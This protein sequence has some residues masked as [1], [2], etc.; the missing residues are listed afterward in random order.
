MKFFKLLPIIVILGLSYSQDCPSNQYVN[1]S[2]SAEVEAWKAAWGDCT[3]YTLEGLQITAND[4]SYLENT[5]SGLR[6]I[7]GDLAFIN[8][9]NLA[10]INDFANLTSIG[11]TL[12]SINTDNL[13]SI[14]G[15]GSN[16]LEVGGIYFVNND[17]LSNCATMPLTNCGLTINS[18]ETTWVNNNECSSININGCDGNCGSFS[19]WD[20]GTVLLDDCA[21]TCDGSATFWTSEC[22][23]FPNS[24]EC[25]MS[26]EDCNDGFG[27]CTCDVNDNIDS[28][29]VVGGDG[30]SCCPSNQNQYVSLSSSAEVEAWKA[31]WGNCGNYT[32]ESLQITANDLSYLE[33]TFSGLRSITGDLAFINLDNL[34]YINDFANL[35]S[36]GGTLRSINTDNLTSIMG[37]GSNGLEVGGIY[38]VNN[39]ALSNCA[40]MPLTN[41]GLTINSGETTWVNNNECSS[42]NINGCD[43][44]CGSFSYW[45]SGTVLL[46]DCAGT[47][48]GPATFWTSECDIY[49][50]NSMECTM[51]QED[52]ND[53][54]GNC[55]CLAGPPVDCV[56][57]WSESSACS[58]GD[59]CGTGTTSQTYTVTT[60]AA[61]GGTACEA[62][63]GAVATAACAGTGTLDNCSVC[64][65][66]DS[67]CTGCADTTANNYDE[68]NTI[69][70]NTACV[71]PV[72]CVGTWSAPTACSEGD[73]CGTGTTSQTYTVTTDAANGG[74]ACEAADGAVATAACDGTGSLDSCSVCNGD[75]STCAGCDGIA[76]SGLVFDEC[77][78][79]NGSGATSDQY[80]TGGACIDFTVCASAQYESTPPTATSDRQCADVTTCASA[81][82]ESTPPTAT[83]D[84]QCADV[85]T[86]PA[87]YGVFDSATETSDTVCGPCLDGTYSGG[88]DLSACTATTTCT[89]GNYISTL[90]TTTSDTVCSTCSICDDGYYASYACEPDST[91]DTVC[92]LSPVD[93]VGSWSAPTACSEGDGCGAG[94]TSSTYTV[95]TAAVGSGAACS[96]ADGDVATVA[97]AGT[98]SLDS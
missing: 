36:I 75:N 11:G 65:G 48:D 88:D 54:F 85:T 81:Q 67:T 57:T 7:T 66:D 33:N 87:G 24:M 80:V 22:A 6:S 41:C 35:T 34:A 30:T 32:L 28:C 31:A 15:L 45:D 69:A 63:D 40:T 89:G 56:G 10:Y 38:F 20:S 78:V 12:R 4:L 1:L 58:E 26:Q 2:S 3:D 42:I 37:L 44:N 53:G 46:D 95:T 77:G 61:N 94:T 76:N 21:G 23:Q 83:S 59:G 93:C 96:D 84:R 49:G 68:G 50:Q 55:T 90:A 9:D 18:G 13:T 98:G 17:A 71:Y 97:C 60:D 8:L 14:M 79:C 52:C 27:N 5:F 92:E 19:Y 72:D 91:V 73:G 16:G 25:T 47:C 70:D 29:G 62:A 82:Y 51:S 86:C 39:D 64:N 43:G 74:T